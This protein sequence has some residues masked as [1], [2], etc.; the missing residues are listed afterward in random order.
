MLNTE[1]V[2]RDIHNGRIL[3]PWGALL[4]DGMALAFMGMALTGAWM[5]WKRRNGV[6]PEG[7]KAIKSRR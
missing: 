6:K 7:K 1:R 2:V 3:G 5:W 4:M